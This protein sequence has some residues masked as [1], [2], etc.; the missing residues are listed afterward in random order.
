MNQT[1]IQ[2]NKRL[3]EIAKTQ[4]Q[5]STQAGLDQAMIQK[6]VVYECGLH[7]VDDEIINDLNE[8]LYVQDGMLRTLRHAYPN[9][10]KVCPI[11]ESEW[12]HNQGL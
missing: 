8:N 12:L 3:A 4:P 5:K 11:C 2:E 6:D 10:G 7:T 9:N 1:V